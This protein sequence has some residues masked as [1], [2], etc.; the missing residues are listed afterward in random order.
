M[1]KT[2]SGKNPAAVALGRLGG[3]VGGKVRSDVKSEAARTNGKL[4]GRPRLSLEERFAR[5]QARD[6]HCSCNDCINALIVAKD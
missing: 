4:G 3:K 1:T 5:H 6:P 2:R